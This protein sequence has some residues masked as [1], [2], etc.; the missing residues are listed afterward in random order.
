MAAE[1]YGISLSSLGTRIKKITITKLL[2]PCRP[3]FALD[4]G[5]EMA[6]LL[7]SSHIR[8]TS[9]SWDTFFFSFEF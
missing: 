8:H 6:I 5:I 4:Q 3:V 7:H 2:G 9:Q 1:E